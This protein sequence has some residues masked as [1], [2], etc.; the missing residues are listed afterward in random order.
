MKHNHRVATPRAASALLALSI[1][2]VSV[3]SLTAGET[4]GFTGAYFGQKTPGLEAEIFAP[5]LIS[6]EGR[7]EFAVSF[8]PGGERL[9]FSVQNA[10]GTVEVLHSQLVEDIWTKPEPVRLGA[11]ARKDEMEAFFSRD[12]KRVFFAPYDEGLDVRIWQV[13]I[14]GDKWVDPSPLDGPIADAPAFFPTSAESGAV[15]YTNIMERQPYRA[16]RGADGAWQIEPLGLESV[17]HPFISPDESFVLVDSRA[18]DSLGKADIY[19]AFA[20]TDGGWSKPVNLGDSVNSEFSETCPSLSNDGK[21]LFF[22][23]YNEPDEVAQIYWVDAG[24]I[25]TARQKQLIEKTVYDSIAWALTKDRARLES[26]IAH[27]DDYFSFHPGGLDGVHG[28]AEFERGFDLWMDQRFKANTTNVRQ[29]RCHLSGSGD[30]AWFSAI[31]DDCYTWD[32]EPGCWKDTRWTG[33]LEIRDGRWQI[34][35]MHFSFASD[36]DGS[37]EE[38]GES[39]D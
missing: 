12:G 4:D 7:Y 19:V 22:S 16:R 14:V 26:I 36:S 10:D 35:Q 24:V 32:G 18:D 28:Y 11:G 31:L 6:V 38:N 2:V 30:V 27:D 17:I 5:G 15:Y 1:L 39:S 8:A 33:V 34:V 13:E 29:F 25:E 20:T 37:S 23:R 3:G 9:L 21:Y